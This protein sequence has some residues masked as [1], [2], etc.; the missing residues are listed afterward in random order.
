M[1]LFWREQYEDEQ[2][3]LEDNLALMENER[4]DISRQEAELE[5]EEAALVQEELDL[6]SELNELQLRSAA[7]Q[8]IRDM[9]IAKLDAV[10]N[11]IANAKYLNILSDMFAIGHTGDYGTINQFRL[12]QLLSQPIEW[13]EINAALGECALL[14]QTLAS[15]IGLDFT[16]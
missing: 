4:E 5:V 8:D 11:K 2:K 3:G 13:N 14:L 1:I 6:W 15:L 16:E 12:G 9:A 10:E 7:F